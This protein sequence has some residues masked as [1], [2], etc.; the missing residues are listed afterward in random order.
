MGT[1][2][3]RTVRDSPARAGHWTANS[4]SHLSR[5]DDALAKARSQRGGRLESAAEACPANRGDVVEVAADDQAASRPGQAHVEVLA[6]AVL[7]AQA[8]DGEHHDRPLEPFEA[9]DMTVEHVLVGEE[10][11]PVAV[12]AVVVEHFL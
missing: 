8:V 5:S 4:A 11:V 1:S 6:A 7:V 3:P 9:E 12:P 10:R 2:R